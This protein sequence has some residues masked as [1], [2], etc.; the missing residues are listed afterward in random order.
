MP[1]YKPEVIV[2]KM[3]QK[4]STRTQVWITNNLHYDTNRWTLSPVIRCERP[5]L[6]WQ[7]TLPKKP[8]AT[9]PLQSETKNTQEKHASSRRDGSLWLHASGPAEER[10]EGPKGFQRSPRRQQLQRRP[11]PLTTRKRNSKKI[12][13]ILWML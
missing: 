2:T 4:N 6:T 8:T 3:P 7:P 1:K 9:S 11:V 5:I 12:T 10:I 13:M